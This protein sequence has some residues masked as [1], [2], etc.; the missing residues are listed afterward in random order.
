MWFRRRRLSGHPRPNRAGAPRP[1]A[2]LEAV[3]ASAPVSFALG[4]LE[5]DLLAGL[6]GE[7]GGVLDRDRP[8]GAVF[9]VQLQDPEGFL[10]ELDPEPDLAAGRDAERLLGQRDPPL[11]LSADADLL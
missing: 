1:E 10:R 5:G 11:L 6:A 9:A 2:E 3:G 7:P 4:C 8:P